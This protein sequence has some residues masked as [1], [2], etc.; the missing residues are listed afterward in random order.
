[1]LVINEVKINNQKM[2]VQKNKE[3]QEHEEVVACIQQLEEVITKA[4]TELLE[5]QILANRKDSETRN[6]SHGI[7]RRGEKG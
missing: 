4:H 6:D 3:M 7:K 1:M 2:F 5:L